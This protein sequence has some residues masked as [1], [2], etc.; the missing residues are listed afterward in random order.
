MF[1]QVNTVIY[2]VLWHQA[3]KA[4]KTMAVWPHD[5]S[6]NFEQNIIAANILQI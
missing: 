2:H 4:H 3:W 6:Q 1:D 5:Y